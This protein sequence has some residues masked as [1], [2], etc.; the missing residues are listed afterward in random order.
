MN[1]TRVKDQGTDQAALANESGGTVSVECDG[2]A[3][4]CSVV[5][6]RERRLAKQVDHVER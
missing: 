1:E 4:G 3:P 5:Q 6:G 2:Q